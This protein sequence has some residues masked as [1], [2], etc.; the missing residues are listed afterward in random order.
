MGKA[1]VSSSATS[2]ALSVCILIV[3][4]IANEIDCE[5]GFAAMSNFPEVENPRVDAVAPSARVALWMRQ[6]YTC[7][8]VQWTQCVDHPNFCLRPG[9]K[10]AGAGE[11]KARKK[12]KG[13][14]Q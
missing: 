2:L 5:P 6:E 3:V 7:G 12:R 14:R 9:A 4:L 10:I 8:F 11:K 13:E 1:R